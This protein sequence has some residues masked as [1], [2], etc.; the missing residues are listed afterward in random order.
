MK[1]SKISE[2]FSQ[3]R[4]VLRGLKSGRGPDDSVVFD[5][6]QHI[7]L[8]LANVFSSMKRIVLSQKAVAE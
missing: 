3:T 6:L 2:Y 1:F 8:N 5:V 4:R 7:C